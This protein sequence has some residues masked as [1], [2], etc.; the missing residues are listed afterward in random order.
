MNPAAPAF[1]TGTRVAGAVLLAGHLSGFAPGA[2]TSM[3]GAMALIT[4]GRVLL[5]DR[6]ESAVA[7]AA[8][9]ITAGAFGVAALRWGTLSLSE[10][11]GAQSVLGPTILVGPGLAATAA[12]GAAGAA[13]IAIAA[14]GAEPQPESRGAWVW[15]AIE[16][17]LVAL[18]ITIVFA[19]PGD[20]GGISHIFSSVGD[21]A[22]TVSF[23][24][25]AIVVGLL[26]RRLLRSAR[27][28]WAVLALCGV[29]VC[30]SAGAMA[31][32]L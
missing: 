18:G 2:I 19:A 3:V 5:L 27:V 30:A 13:V 14:W 9:A 8:L 1:S 25:A 22:P 28:R 17:G 15:D 16:V 24:A 10:L 26:G 21:W 29:A 6:N 20:G 11:V 32:T 31:A 23:I 12:A 7:G 4:L